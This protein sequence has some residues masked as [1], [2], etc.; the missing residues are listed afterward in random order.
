MV[1]YTE[2]IVFPLWLENIEKI[3]QHVLLTKLW[4]NGHFP[5]LL[6]RTQ[7][8]TTFLE[9]NLSIPN[10]IIL[11]LYFSWTICLVGIY[12]KV[13]LWKTKTVCA[14]GYSLQ[15]SLS[16][17]NTGNNYNIHSNILAWRIPWTEESCGLVHSVTELDMTEATWHAHTISI[18]KTVLN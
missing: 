9:G 12:L 3:W 18:Q 4:R 14:E 16:L 1:I 15:H 17:K 11:Y 2:I 10:T 13:I 5:T 8:D 7:I 6:V